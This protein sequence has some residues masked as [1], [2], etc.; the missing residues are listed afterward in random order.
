MKRGYDLSQSAEDDLRD[1]V[2]Y[3]RQLWGDS[4][5][6]HY[7][8]VLKSGIERVAAGQGIFKDMTAIHPRLRMVHC[9]HHYIF[10]LARE[11]EPALIVAILHE[12]MDLMARLS[13][14]LT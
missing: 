14:R 10:C 8:A 1:I 2:R 3:T 5:A 12:R 11:N 4:Q 7:V 9:R 6:R 13:D